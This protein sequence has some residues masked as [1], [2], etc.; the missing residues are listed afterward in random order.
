MGIIRDR[1]TVA[2]ASVV[3]LEQ[4][5]T[6]SRRVS[7][8]G[9]D[10]FCTVVF[11]CPPRFGTTHDEN[12]ITDAVEQFLRT[13]KMVSMSMTSRPWQHPVPALRL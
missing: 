5:E 1:R 6:V 13:G 2:R 3:V 9:S 7:G 10:T 11:K 12:D 4:C 8:F